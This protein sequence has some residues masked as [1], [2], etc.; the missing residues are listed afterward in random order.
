MVTSS[1]KRASKPYGPP[2]SSKAPPPPP[3]PK[4][5]R[6][7]PP[8]SL[9]EREPPPTVQTIRSGQERAT[10][11]TEVAHKAFCTCIPY[12]QQNCNQCNKVSSHKCTQKPNVPLLLD[13]S[14]KSKD[15]NCVDM[16]Y[17][18]F[19][20]RCLVTEQID[21][22]NSME[23]KVDGLKQDINELRNTL[24]HVLKLNSTA[25]V[26]SNIEPCDA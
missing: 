12:Q 7:S 4:L 19:K 8:S 22:I 26:E 15:D 23:R 6:P 25:C 11:Y 5:H 18:F 13:T 2:P 14:S 9:E 16:A 17:E 1:S 20:L 10:H 3:P 24:A 21:C